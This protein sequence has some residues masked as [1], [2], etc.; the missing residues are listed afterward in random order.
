MGCSSLAGVSW[1]PWA[2]PMGLHDLNVD[3]FEKELQRVDQMGQQVK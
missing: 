3:E 1:E 2:L